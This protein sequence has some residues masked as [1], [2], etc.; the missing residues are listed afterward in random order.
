MLDHARSIFECVVD[1]RESIRLLNGNRGDGRSQSTPMDYRMGKSYS[2][3]KEKEVEPE[4]EAE[5]KW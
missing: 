5:I 4:V 1:G 2:R 3:K